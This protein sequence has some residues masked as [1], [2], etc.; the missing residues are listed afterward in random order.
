METAFQ[1]PQTHLTA[2]AL[3]P[4]LAIQERLYAVR[5]VH[6]RAANRFPAHI[7][8]PFP[9]PQDLDATVSKLRTSF[10]E[11]PLQTFRLDFAPEPGVFT[12]RREVTV[13]LQPRNEA[14]LSI[15]S[16]WL[17]I[18][19]AA[20]EDNFKDDERRPFSPHLT[21]GQAPHN[22]TSIQLLM[23][24]AAQL[25][26][27]LETWMVESFVV[28]RKDIDDDGLMKPYAVVSL[29]GSTNPLTCPTLRTRAWPVYRFV[30]PE[31]GWSANHPA[32][33]DTSSS[34][35]LA[36]QVRIA[37]ATAVAGQVAGLLV[38]FPT[39]EDIVII[40]GITDG[41]IESILANKQVQRQFSW[42]S[43]GPGS[44]LEL[45]QS[46]I[47]LATSSAGPLTLTHRDRWHIASGLFGRIGVP[48]S[49]SLATHPEGI[50]TVDVIVCGETQQVTPPPGFTLSGGFLVAHGRSGAP[51]MAS[52]ANWESVD[53]QPSSFTPEHQAQDTDTTEVSEVPFNDDDLRSAL[54]DTFS[55]WSPEISLIETSDLLDRL[56]QHFASELHSTPSRTSVVRLAFSLVGA[57]AF[58]LV[59]PSVDSDPIEVVAVG[60]ISARAFRGLLS[61]RFGEECVSV[62]KESGS[63][64]VSLDGN[65]LVQVGYCCEPQLVE[66]W[67]D[68]REI[69]AGP[70]VKGSEGVLRDPSSSI[71]RGLST[72]FR[73][74]TSASTPN[75]LT[76]AFR[77]V[78]ALCLAR[79]VWS[80][81]YGYVESTKL[82]PA[83]ALAAS[84]HS[85]SPSRVA[86]EAMNRLSAARNTNH[87]AIPFTV[88]SIC[89]DLAQGSTLGNLLLQSEIK[90]FVRRNFAAFIQI[91]LSYWGSGSSSQKKE[92][93]ARVEDTLIKISQ[94]WPA[95]AHLW[96]ERLRAPQLEEGTVSWLIGVSATTGP[97]LSDSVE[98]A[99]QSI[100]EDSFITVTSLKP[101][102]PVDLHPATS[103]A[104]PP[105][106]PQVETEPAAPFKATTTT[107][108]PK[109]RTS[110]DV[111]NRLYWN[112]PGGTSPDE[113]VIGYEDRF[114]GIREAPLRSWKR[115]VE[116]EAFIP[117]HRVLHY[118]RTTDDVVVWDRLKRL[119]LIFGSGSI[120]T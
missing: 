120:K 93:V 39:D 55:Q 25:L 8:L 53:L 80:R 68:R 74:E 29:S 1:Q 63:S 16:L 22:N 36:R 92:I 105:I 91:D 117:F 89:K 115:D 32:T 45:D 60:N 64:L 106:S 46:S 41:D 110:T 79:G 65:Q 9:E 99:L 67:S 88:D 82:F 107:P 18:M 81:R 7:T 52:G 90:S 119:D 116:D 95:P 21:I 24:R 17:R 66:R 98:D 48:M 70:S 62:D 10:G 75:T 49:H 11:A 28:L 40:T 114:D 50:P 78:R 15:R 14:L 51:A 20:T 31:I 77:A 3:V 84:Q 59:S 26:Q 5:A 96:P 34:G 72:R 37:H 69:L 33:R 102:D 57:S 104:Q 94:D 35:T 54:A 13:H 113:Y 108:P 56:E 109:L 42:S 112:P 19:R 4:S 83:I 100:A 27:R 97:S 30:S 38:D 6:D 85:A 76:M 47:I 2:L 86:W 12:G 103:S 118:R 71:L 87:K 61:E 58:G 44:V 23:D 101:G 111:F 73:L 43:R